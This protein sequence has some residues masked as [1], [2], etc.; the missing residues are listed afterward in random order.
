MPTV[1]RQRAALFARRPVG[2]IAVYGPDATLA[3]KL[4]VSVVDRSRRGEP[5]AMRAWTS[6]SVDVRHD[7][8][9]ANEVTDFLREQGATDTVTSDRMMGCPHEEGVDYPMGRTCPRCPFWAGI[10]RFTHEPIA[11]LVP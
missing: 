8:T 1:R 6:Q 10:D 2:T 5:V 11:V 7:P 9:I 3:T 4:V